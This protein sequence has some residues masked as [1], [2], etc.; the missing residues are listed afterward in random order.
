M[1]GAPVQAPRERLDDIGLYKRLYSLEAPV[2][3]EPAPLGKA[4]VVREGADLTIVLAMRG[5]HDSL[6][7]AD[8]L[9]RA[10]ID[11][12]VL[13]LRTLRPFD[14]QTVL[15]SVAKTNRIVVVEEGPLTDGWAAEVLA[16]V[17]EKALGD[18]DDAWPIATPNSP[19]PYSPSLGDAFLPGPTRIAQEIRARVG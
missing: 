12:E 17:T 19:I 18:L 4:D 9:A 7:A 1:S 16:V 14:A 6:E 15:D 5:V 13:D 3:E 10:G 11:A 2:K 8:E